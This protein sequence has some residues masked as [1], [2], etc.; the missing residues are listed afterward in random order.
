MPEL[1]TNEKKKASVEYLS[2]S[3]RNVNRTEKTTRGYIMKTAGPGGIP[4]SDTKGGTEEMKRIALRPYL[5]L[6][7]SFIILNAKPQGGVNEDLHCDL[8]DGGL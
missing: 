1:R 7:L 3:L 6:F 2:E 4:F 8:G 5:F